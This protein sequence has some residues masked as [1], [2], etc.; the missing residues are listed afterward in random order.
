MKASANEKKQAALEGEIKDMDNV[1]DA[2]SKGALA[3]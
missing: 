3:F 1:Y 2:K